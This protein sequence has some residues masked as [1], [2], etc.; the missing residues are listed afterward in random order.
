LIGF[1]VNTLALR[2]DLSGDPSF[3]ELLGR[4]KETALGAYAHQDLPFEKLVEELQPVRDLSR[5]PIF[6]AVL[7]LQNVPQ[8]TLQLPG[9]R[10]SRLGDGNQTAKFDL[11][12]F[13]HE[14]PSGLL[15]HFEYAADLFDRTTIERLSGHFA[16]LL[17][18]IVTSPD[19]R[20]L[21]LPLLTA[22]E[23]H[24][25]VTEWNDT[26]ADY[27]SERCVHELFAAQAE[28][29]PDS[30][31]VVYED[32]QLSYGELDHRSNQLAHHLRGL[33][34]G[35]EVVVGLCV[36]RSLE[37]VVWLLG[38]LKAG[39][40]YLPLDPSY[41][42]E[43]LSY[44]LGDAH[45]PVVVRQSALAGQMPA[46]NARL[47]QLD[48]DWAQIARQPAS[49][50]ASGTGPDNLAYVIYTSGSTGKPK[51]VMV[52]HGGVTNYLD[53]A[54]SAYAV[55]GPS[56]A[57]VSTPLSFDATV[58]SL[59]V[60]LVSGRSTRL[61]PDNEDFDALGAML[62]A[63]DKFG[64][65]KVT[66]THLDVL[67]QTLS[68][69]TFAGQR[70][71][72]VIGGEAL[73]ADTIKQLRED[74][75]QVRLFNEY[76]PTETVVGCAVYE[77]DAETRW[78]GSVPI[79]R[80]IWNTQVYV[81]DGLLEPLPV[82]VLGEL[83]I[84][85]A[86]VARG[87]LG[88]PSLT[89]ERFV[90]SPF[91]EGERLYRTGDLGRWRPD[92]ELEYLGRTDHQVKVRGYR[93]ELGEIEA[94][95]CAHPS[96]WQAV[97]VAREDAPGEKRLVGYV[98]GAEGVAPE[99]GELRGH[100]QRSLPDYM[101]PSAFVALDALPL[102]PN[103]K[104][105]R[106]ALPAPEGRPEIDEYVAPRTPVE[107]VL[108]GIWC[109]VLRLDRVGV[110]DN[111][112]ELGGHSLLAMRMIVRVGNA[113]EV[114]LPLRAW[115]EAPTVCELAE[116]VAAAQR[117][118]LELAVPALV[119]GSRPAVLPLSHAQERLW[120][121]EQIASVGSAYHVTVSVRLRGQ[122]DE[123]ALERSF[124]EVVERHEALRTRFSSIDGTPVQVIDAVGGFGLQQIDLRGVD[125]EE[126]ERE[127]RRRARAIAGAAFDLAS[128]PLFRAVLLR[129]TAEEHVAVVVMHHI[130]SD[131]WSLGVLIREIGA[132]YA[133]YVEG[134]PSP[135][136]DLPVQYADYALW[137]REWLHGEVLERQ[138]GYWRDRLKDAP[139]A[140]EL[141]TDR[142]RP[143]VQSYHGASHGFRL[144]TE[145]GAAL[146]DLARREGATLFM[147]L[148]AAFQVLL[149]RWSG[150]TDVVVG[151]PI[152]GRTHR[153]TEGLIGF[154][155]NML[156][157]RTDLSG[158]PSCRELL[159][160]V[161][162]TALGAYAHQDLPFEKLVEELQPVRD[163]SRQP[164]F[165]VL[166]AFQNVPQETLE[167]P[168]LKLSRSGGEQ[169]TAK[170]D[171]SL[172][173]QETD[174]GLRGHFEYATDL[175]D[176]STIERLAGHFERLLEG[177]V[178]D[179]DSTISALPLVGEAERHRLL[180]EWNATAADYPRQKCLHELFAA[181]AGRTPDAI[182]V[183]FE[184]LQLSYGE[185]DR[186]ANQLGHHLRGVGIGVESVIGLCVERSLE[187]V[188]GLL[189]ILKAGAAYLPLD[190]S[191]P[192]ERL[193]YMLADA[194]VRV[195]VTQERLLDEVSG[196]DARLVRLD[197][198]WQEIA[199]E[200]EEALASGVGPDNLAYVIYTSG[201]TGR[202]KGVMVSHGAMTNFLSSMAEAPGLEASDTMA[203]VTPLSFD[204]AGLE[205]YLPLMRGA[206]LAVMGRAVVVDGRQLR[207]RLAAVG[208]SV[209]QATPATW[210]LLR[211]AGWA[212]GGVKVLC[213]GEALAV[214]LAQWLRGGAAQVWNLYGPTETTI[215]STASRVE[216]NGPVMIGRPISNTLVYVLD[217]ELQPVPIGVCGE[218]YLGGHGMAR[219]YVNRSGLTGERFVPDPFG[220][221][222]RLYRTGDLGR[223][224]SDGELEY[225]GR[226]DHQVKLR[227]YRIE[228]GEI[229]AA[230][231]GDP[232]VK[233]CVVVAREDVPG[234]QR[235]VAYVVGGSEVDTATAPMQFSLFY[236]AEGEESEEEEKYRLYI[237]GAKIAD[238]LGLS[239]VWTPERH[240]TEIGA[241]YPNPSV[242]S[243][244]LA[245]VTEHIQ[246]RAGSVVL[247]LH[248]PMRVAEEW[249]V[250]DNLSGGRVGV[251]FASGWVPN[252]FVFAPG[253]YADRH[254]LMLE[255]VAQVQK[256]WRG[257]AVGLT[258]G[259]GQEVPV[260]M[261]PRPVQ[262]E[263]PIWLT[264][265]QS[266]KTFEAAGALGVNVL[267]A[268]MTQTMSD[269]A[270]KIALY[271]ETLRRHGHDP[272]RGVVSVMLH[273]FVAPTDEAARQTVDGP[274]AAY[275][276]SHAYLRELVL[277]TRDVPFPID[278]ADIE[279]L[280]PL[281]LERYLSTSS[282]IGSPASCLRMVQRL[283]E[284]GVDE[285][286]CLIDFG[287]STDVVLANLEHLQ[288][289]AEESRTILDTGALRARL[290]KQLPDYMLPSAFVRL[291]TLPLTPNGK[292]D[293]K[294]L[295]APDVRPS[296]IEY[297]APRTSTEQL[298][299]EIWRDLLKL[300]RIGIDDNF[301]ELGGHS[302]LAMRMVA[303]VR[304]AF[305][306]ELPLRAL[307]EA[308][309]IVDLAEKITQEQPR[310][311]Q[312][313]DLRTQ[314]ARMSSEEVRAML[315][316][317]KLERRS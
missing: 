43:R 37:M 238:R 118:G 16:V 25:V 230:L 293:R 113:F 196:Y 203:A 221:G 70:F 214:D 73:M 74:A 193:S 86:G 251:S 141:P 88:R 178:A 265:A 235:L 279:R 123:G 244:A 85:G 114:D 313:I 110:H 262:A 77:I 128:G 182:A 46:G 198:D 314:V 127:V 180:S 276:R 58:T 14:V 243:A 191:H 273:T 207:E 271:R 211:E 39:G 150:Q 192:A 90:S 227:G 307:F 289:L 264:A 303:R 242:L 246:L 30:V 63:G 267:T 93:I 316:E 304:Q 1:F 286:A 12:L 256:L 135:L 131:G 200:P 310:I 115:F 248:H 96:V 36:E 153:E 75:P 296:G 209:I 266:P 228:L 28:R 71:A 205:I 17:E 40:A 237:E 176:G 290:R 69:S 79:G 10:L 195:L 294:G 166:L 105:D 168:G 101:V 5:Q 236:F 47:V 255:G 129:L 204:I 231:R 99:A 263:L 95:L 287:V 8:E 120:L 305:N 291:D 45:C 282:L 98:V 20:L 218:L 165:Q 119:A 239:A 64:L 126:R 292:L 222:E 42:C 161:R 257:E 219:G 169:V 2:T 181:Q 250:V 19:R 185:L 278:H 78:T 147:V 179:P 82:G 188:I 55:A 146:N 315:H 48:A 68:A 274:L 199:D 6:Q 142:A 157:L 160:Q 189:G 283:K 220:D 4:V 84:G 145:L 217:G 213:G 44:M 154:F 11:V 104:V 232:G 13:V 163:L 259:V 130:V 27:P 234:E 53:Y 35:P 108:A 106:K 94:A 270:E 83:Y 89:A 136:P 117:E 309:T 60:P 140:L 170:F 125:E 116:R 122:L 284:I 301:F 298:L 76:G 297:V 65:L 187:M 152:A 159:G 299:A 158:H 62:R 91:G 103:G 194:K 277:K 107:E 151:T 312:V 268:L 252:D 285:I 7:T 29:T 33:G 51:G 295:P 137:Q 31:A 143:P 155:V 260:R 9:L 124:A 317:L 197:G 241:A 21:E 261:L 109:E 164:I 190:P 67:K 306:I 249:S 254:R 24:L 223:W 52:R 18:G 275:L 32:Q 81:L 247:P 174:Q 300:E 167:L 258:N 308:A 229:E 102:T 133:A 311:A 100:V 112:F 206:R 186:R 56:R 138:V 175:F 201:S 253:A 149:S 134:K 26:A 172:Y 92:G 269:L 202:P 87:Y 240:F 97:V 171:L 80:P 57:L 288:T 184:D 148:V 61:L 3:R 34:V 54:S 156:A 210:R 177:I 272:A 224:R 162:E 111:F 66:P 173:V 121:L 281:S 212:G 15:G 49:A 59:I 144:S 41:P 183:V 23:R 226:I 22:G 139:A 208:T 245:T 215:W 72:V 50:V 216:R 280:I 38:I 225:L 302:L 132:L 233:D